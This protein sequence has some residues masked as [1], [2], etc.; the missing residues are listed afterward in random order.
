VSTTTNYVATT[1]SVG[2]TCSSMG[3]RI[4]GSIPPAPNPR[5]RRSKCGGLMQR[6]SHGLSRL[7]QFLSHELFECSS[8][9]RRVKM[10]PRGLT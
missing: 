10:V 3:S 5:V 9:K 4:V 2:L 6:L 1:E 7:E 8:C